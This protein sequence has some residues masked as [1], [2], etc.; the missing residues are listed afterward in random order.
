MMGFNAP[1]HIWCP[2]MTNTPNEIGFIR[3]HG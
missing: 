1:H 2:D 3:L